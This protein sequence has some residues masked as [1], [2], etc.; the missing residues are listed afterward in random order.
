MNNMTVAQSSNQTNLQIN[1]TVQILVIDDDPL[2]QLIVGKML[3][4]QGYEVIVARNGEEGIQKAQQFCPAMIICDWQMPEMSGLQVCC[5]I[6]S[7]PTLCKIFFIL[8]TARTTVEDRVEGLDM[9]ADDFLSKPIEGSELKARV[10]AGLRL[11][12]SNQALQQSAQE[13]Q[14]Q[15]QILEAEL[16]EAAE[17]VRSILPTPI[18]G[19]VTIEPRFIPSRELGGDCFDYYWLDPDYLAIYLLDVSGHGLGSALPSVSI[20]N[21]LRS[22]SLSGVNFYQP[23]TV[24]TTLNEIFQMSKQNSRY[25]TMWYGVYNQRKRQLSYA[26]AGHP[27]AILLSK[28]VNGES[29]VKRLRTRGAAIGVLPDTKF[30]T[31]FCTVEESS[32]LYIFSDGVYEIRQADGTFWNLNEFINLLATFSDKATFSN[33]D[34]ILQHILALS[35]KNTFEDDCSLLQIELA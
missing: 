25:F 30:V 2:T 21:M 5:Y 31:E 12:H 28:S 23:A 8:L 24:L 13:L 22:Q 9:G 26:S 4:G 32:T 19:R 11:Y 27:P 18:T 6:K 15:K 10:R 14:A 3:Q 34:D 17:Y 35:G 1:R 33:P 29:Q 7:D 16:A 20:H